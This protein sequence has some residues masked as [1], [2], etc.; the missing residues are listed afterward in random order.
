MLFSQVAT[1]F[2]DAYWAQNADVTTNVT[3]PALKEIFF[4]IDRLQSSPPSAEELKAIQSYASGLFVLQNSSRAG[5][6]QMLRFADM[7]DL[8]DSYL[9]NYVKA[10]NSVTR[11]VRKRMKIFSP[12]R[13]MMLSS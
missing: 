13:S 12:L 1:H 3:G 7:H 11:R 10:V 4:E 6:L 8:P 2:R 5:I 9:E